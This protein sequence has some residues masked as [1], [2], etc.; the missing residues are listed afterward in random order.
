MQEHACRQS[1]AGAESAA[2]QEAQ[3]A[4]YIT[5]TEQQ[6][7]E[8]AAYYF[9]HYAV[10]LDFCTKQSPQAYNRLHRR[11]IAEHLRNCKGV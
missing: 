11:R 7:H 10:R 9:E 8:I 4:Q 2:G 3:E 6:T 1:T 5:R